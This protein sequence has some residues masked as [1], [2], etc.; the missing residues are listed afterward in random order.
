MASSDDADL[1]R[2]DGRLPGLTHLL[3]PDAM[4]AAL[5]AAGVD[6]SWIACDYLRY[7][8]RTNCVA[9]LRWRVARRNGTGYAKAYPKEAREKITAARRRARDRQDP[10]DLPPVLDEPA[11]VLHPYPV[12]EKL[13]ALER[14]GGMAS[15]RELLQTLFPDR[16][17]VQC[18]DIHV[19]KYKPERRCV[20]ALSLDDRRVAAV[21]FYTAAAYESARES[22]KGLRSHGPLQMAKRL[23]R[24]NR[25]RIV[26]TQWLA[27]RSLDEL[28]QQGDGVQETVEHVGAA[29][30]SLHRQRCRHLTTSTPGDQ[31]AAIGATA[32]TLEFLCPQFGGQVRQIARRLVEQCHAT[33]YSA[34]TIHGDFYA[35]QVVVDTD[36][37]AIVD[38]DDAVRGNP[39]TDLGCF[40]AH[41]EQA[42]LRGPS[43]LPQVDRLAGSL[44]EGYLRSATPEQA[45]AGESVRLQLATAIALFRL[46][47]EPF[48]NRESDWG[49]GIGRVIDRT[50]QL[51]DGLPPA[52][53]PAKHRSQ[54]RSGSVP[55]SD[56]DALPPG[57]GAEVKGHGVAGGGGECSAGHERPS[58]VQ[59][60]DP[61]RARSDARMTFLPRALDPRQVRRV[62]A[63]RFP[64][65]MPRDGRID[66]RRI[67]VLHYKSLRRC[68]VQYDLFDRE[69]GRAHCLLGKCHAKRR[70][71]A[72]Y[73]LQVALRRAGFAEEAGG[74]TRVPRPVGT[75][76]D[77]QMW[78]QEKV[79]GEDSTEALAGPGGTMLAIRIADA[80]VK[81]HRAGVLTTR[82][83]KMADELLILRSRLQAVAQWRPEWRERLEYVFRK[84]A[85]LGDRVA[86]ARMCGIHRDFHPGQVLVDGEGL[87]L[88]DFDLYAHGDPGLDVG[89]F[90]GHLIELALRKRGDS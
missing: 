2:R 28:I 24:S 12:D 40:V 52:A 18:A 71:H 69:T 9:A 50:Q 29:L 32:S 86:P 47:P 36:R 26:A 44:L 57:L 11:L 45:V 31:V 83:H 88:I 42:S 30:A 75:I 41:L 89:N 85:E 19:V 90:A 1:I 64:Q 61:F 63:E 4:A 49:T 17:D 73:A 53:R 54:N 77:W 5:R 22:A 60:D 15:Q 82:R 76:P 84:S 48:R 70:E 81:L 16:P 74:G 87:V 55:Q 80:I 27:G 39:A 59:V 37:V 34:V 35:R 51:I 33:L 20:I 56:N 62:L 14:L 7:K 13:P 43:G 46:A 72:A 66:L 8:P 65:L 3:D 21:K 58:A 6:V 78:L 10:S 68:V 79:P 38:L 67:E 25:H 23:G